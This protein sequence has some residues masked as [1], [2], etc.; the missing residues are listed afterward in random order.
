[1]SYKMTR[2][3]IQANFD[4]VETAHR[5]SKNAYNK[6][7]DDSWCKKNKKKMYRK[8]AENKE[9]ERKE[10]AKIKDFK[11]TTNN[12][13][14][15]QKHKNLI[16]EQKKFDFIYLGDSENLFL[17]FPIKTW[18]FGRFITKKYRK[19]IHKFLM[20]NRKIF[21]FEFKSFLKS[22]HWYHK[23]TDYDRITRCGFVTRPSLGRRTSV[24]FVLRVNKSNKQ[25]Y[26]FDTKYIKNI[27]IIDNGL[28]KTEKI[29]IEHERTR[30][31]EKIYIEHDPLIVSKEFWD[32]LIDK[33]CVVDHFNKRNAVF[34]YSK[35]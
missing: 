16:D 4:P 12:N 26:I 5:R 15:K 33:W 28:Y 6:F 22:Y 27:Y 35:R 34:V 3:N 20:D 1:M 8:Q 29:P 25:K 13:K 17:A 7:K 21:D 9:Q 18:L 2:Q 11:R 31:F 10:K 30:R 19:S 14:K 23:N 24:Y 32:Y